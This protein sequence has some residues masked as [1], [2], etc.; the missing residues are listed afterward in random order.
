MVT[1]GLPGPVVSASPDEHHEGEKGRG[2]HNERQALPKHGRWLG[3]RSDAGVIGDVGDLQDR[4][5]TEV[6]A[7]GCPVQP[8]S[9]LGS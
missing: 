8:A 1:D 3:R 2:T 4:S 6:V 7:G 5:D 9:G